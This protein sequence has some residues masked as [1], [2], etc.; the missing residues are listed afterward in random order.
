MADTKF[1]TVLGSIKA[2]ETLASKFASAATLAGEGAT[3]RAGTTRITVVVVGGAVHWHTTGTPTSSFG[4]AVA[5]GKPITLE[6]N[7][8]KAKFIDDA[9]SGR[10]II[11]AYHK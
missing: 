5:A 3:I 2:M 4:H 11:M 1:D 10:T 6:H 7:Q 9:G 8:F